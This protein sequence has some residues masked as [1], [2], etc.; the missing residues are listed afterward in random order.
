VVEGKR[1][2]VYDRSP[3]ETAF[4]RWQEGKFL[5]IERENARR[6]RA[7]LK[8]VD[9]KVSADKLKETGIDATNCRS[10]DHAYALAR[11]M[12]ERTE[13]PWQRIALAVAILELPRDYE[14]RVVERW[15]I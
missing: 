5:Q 7:G 12:V 4:S 10:L 11:G 8:Q 6:W 2:I 1:A 9:L 14:Y 3:T 13:K 15:N